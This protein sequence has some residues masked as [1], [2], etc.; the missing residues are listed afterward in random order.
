MRKGSG[1]FFPCSNSYF[2]RKNLKN[3]TPKKQGNPAL[4]S[5]N[6]GS[7]FIIKRSSSSTMHCLRFACGILIAMSIMLLNEF[8]YP[9]R[10]Y[11]TDGGG[12]GAAA[13]F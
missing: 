2:E 8:V 10:F 7:A 5:F 13:W 6:N 9:A 4:V 3:S 12:G 11:E 1:N